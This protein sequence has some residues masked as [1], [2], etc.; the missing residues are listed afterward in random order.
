MLK[1]NEASVHK[2]RNVKAYLEM[3]RQ[4]RAPVA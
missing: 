1:G 3:I 4:V 2:H